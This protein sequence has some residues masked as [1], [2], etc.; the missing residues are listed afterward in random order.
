LK[1][2]LGLF[3][4][5]ALAL[6]ANA[7]SATLGTGSIAGTITDSVTGLP[8]GGA[9]V[10]AGGC[11]LYAMTADDGTYIIE[12][13]AAGDYTVK[14]MK[15]GAYVMKAYPTPVHVEDGQAVTGIDIALAPVGGGGG[16]GSISGTVYDKATNEPI[17]G[18][19]VMVGCHNS[20]LTGE[21]GTYTITGLADGSYTVKAMKSGYKCA[22][23]PNPVVIQGG[24]AVT[25]IDFYLDACSYKA[26]D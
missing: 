7:P 20:A 23:Y 1:N 11:G 15:C 17:E 24:G 4:C 18:A 21:D 6:G 2:L 16:N 10:T 25:G 13:L 26:L 12:N 19:K 14:A 5:V 8:I 3:F 22:T 9:K